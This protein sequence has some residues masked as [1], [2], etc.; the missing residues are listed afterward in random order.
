MPGLRA[1]FWLVCSSDR[2]GAAND[3]TW[4]IFQGFLADKKCLPL[5]GPFVWWT[6][7]GLSFP[8][9]AYALPPSR[10]FFTEIFKCK[11]FRK[12]TMLLQQTWVDAQSK[13]R[14]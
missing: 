8:K 6:V 12:P 11:D 2:P 1:E 3:V 14:Q 4:L 13:I 10:G 9:W 5:S 7:C